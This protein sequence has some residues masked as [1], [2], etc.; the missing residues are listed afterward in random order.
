M[1]YI[2]RKNKVLFRR[3]KGNF[4]VF[5]NK[6]FSIKFIIKLFFPILFSLVVIIILMIF[7]IVNGYNARIINSE[8]NIPEEFEIG[9]VLFFGTDSKEVTSELIKSAVTLYKDRR[10]KTVY[11]IGIDETNNGV[12]SESEFS[13]L[14]KEI[15]GEK[16]F[17]AL[18]S[19]S[20]YQMCIKLKS[21]YNLDKILLISYNT[22]LIRASY[23][24][25]STSLLTFAFSPKSSPEYSLTTSFYRSIFADFVRLSLNMNLN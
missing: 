12:L 13:P 10:L 15:P 24:C 2:S 23:T 22:L 17:Y 18:N 21:D 19:R 20:I 7:S 1:T 11:V 25:N 4:T 6:I 16:V 8:S 14:L 3:I 9:G 5:F